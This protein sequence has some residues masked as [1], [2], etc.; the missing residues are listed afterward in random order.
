MVNWLPLAVYKK[1]SIII[2]T[3]NL[4]T[5]A[6]HLVKPSNVNSET[7]FYI[8][9]TCSKIMQR[10]STINR[11]DNK[12]PISS[13]KKKKTPST[14]RWWIL[15]CNS[16]PD[17]TLRISTSS[18]KCCRCLDD[19]SSSSRRHASSSRAEAPLSSYDV[20]TINHALVSQ[21]CTNTPRWG[22]ADC[23][24]FSLMVCLRHG[25]H[26]SSNLQHTTHTCS[27]S[28]CCWW[29]CSFSVVYACVSS[30]RAV[31]CCCSS[32]KTWEDKKS[33]TI[34]SIEHLENIHSAPLHII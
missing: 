13:L 28:W 32:S 6:F 30:W 24:N 25:Q 31:L 9:Y 27:W 22:M 1:K 3:S 7:C 29:S 11:K 16:S 33:F 26:V 14:F 10:L 20:A 34:R 21:N 19:D 15:S 8:N 23:L 18:R 17:W 5:F 4:N 2:S 12:S